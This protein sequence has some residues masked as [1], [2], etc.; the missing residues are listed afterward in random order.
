MNYI[1]WVI[2][3]NFNNGFLKE[4]LLQV[5][6]KFPFREPKIFTKGNYHCKIDREFVWFQGYE[7]IFYLDKNK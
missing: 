7:N 4:A 3:S 6:E 5:T 2:G 1:G